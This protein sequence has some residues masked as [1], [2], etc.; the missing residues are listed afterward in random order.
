MHLDDKLKVIDTECFFFSSLILRFIYDN[1][2][3]SRNCEY[4]L[5]SNPTYLIIIILPFVIE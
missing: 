2:R 5:G 4:S 1:I 3:E